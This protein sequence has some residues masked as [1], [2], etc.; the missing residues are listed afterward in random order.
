MEKN[1][2]WAYDVLSTSN[3]KVG[4]RIRSKRRNADVHGTI[5][6]FNEGDKNFY[7]YL[8]KWDNG[9]EEKCRGGELRIPA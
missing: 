4:D 5:I 7:P 8:I 6:A 3:P 1:H 2:W 9:E